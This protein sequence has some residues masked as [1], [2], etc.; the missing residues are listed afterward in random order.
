MDQDDIILVTL[1]YRLGP[2]GFLKL[3]T[4]NGNDLHYP[5][6]NMGLKD[7]NLALRWIQANIAFFGGDPNRVT[8]FGESAGG[9]SVHLHMLSPQSRGLVHKAIALSGSAFNPWALSKDVKKVSQK[10]V[11]SLGCPNDGELLL[12]CLHNADAGEMV[13]L[14]Q[15]LQEPTVQNDLLIPTVEEVITEDT[16]LAE[17]PVDI[18]NSGRGAKIPL[19]LGVNSGEGGLITARKFYKVNGQKIFN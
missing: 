11:K 8:L 17:Y 18:V 13:K 7:Q 10:F 16:F 15:V 9:A 2:F 12:E 5:R 1:N 3:N 4:G 14:Q 6:G 19:I